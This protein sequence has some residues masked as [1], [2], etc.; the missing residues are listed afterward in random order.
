MGAFVT[1]YTSSA[2]EERCWQP[3]G[4]QRPLVANTAK[5]G[6]RQEASHACK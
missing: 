3:Y 1:F 6:L 2:S 4:H 5:L